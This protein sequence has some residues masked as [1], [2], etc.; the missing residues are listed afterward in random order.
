MKLNSGRPVRVFINQPSK[1]QPLHKYHGKYAIA[2]PEDGPICDIHFTEGAVHS[3]R[4][5]K[6]SLNIVK[7]SSAED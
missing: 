1:S 2:I 6:L 3:S 5:P 7:L 4:V